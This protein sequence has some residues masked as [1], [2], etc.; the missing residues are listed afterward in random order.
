[1]FKKAITLSVSK[2]LEKVFSFLI[3]ITLTY[4]FAQGEVGRFFYYFSL[5][6]LTIPV[7]DF[8][9]RKILVL[10]WN[11]QNPSEN[12]KLIA[13]IIITKIMLGTIC[14]GVVLLVDFAINYNT[15]APEA[16]ILCFIAIFSDELGQ[17]FR[18]PDHANQK[19]SFEIVTPLLSRLLC[20]IS[21][22]VFKENL[23]SIENALIFYA[24]WNTIGA[25][26]SFISYLS[27]KPKISISH[28]K[29]N[30]KIYLKEGYAFSLTSFFVM[31]SFYVDSVILGAYSLEET[32]IYNCAFRIILVFG[33]LSSGFSHVLFSKFASDKGSIKDSAKLLK[34]ITPLVVTLF[35]CIAIGTLALNKQAIGAI[36]SKEFEEASTIL[37]VLTPFILFSALSNIFAHALEAN[38]LQKKVMTFN[39]ISC[40]FNIITNLIFIPYWGMYAAALTTVVTEFLNLTLS[41][42]LLRNA[43]VN[44]FEKFP[45][46]C[47]NLIILIALVGCIAHFLPLIPGIIL[48]AMAFIPLYIRVFKKTNQLQG[49]LK[50][51]S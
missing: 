35:A 22:L 32:G 8:G 3:I 6:S 14:L 29:T 27:Y 5:V 17:I 13:S 39:I 7:M 23:I 30:M 2:F 10:K 47:R 18:A 42:L 31:I 9:L 37:I 38:G 45:T 48:G 41:Y 44:P 51:V 36:Y 19:F 15:F 1:M 40:F 26:L 24:I 4:I 33:I 25:L 49:E 12:S 28:T 21:I 43:G 34:K 46:I 16:V 20:F 50:C 11:K